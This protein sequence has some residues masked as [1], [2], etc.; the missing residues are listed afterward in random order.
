[1]DPE[2]ISDDMQSPPSQSAGPGIRLPVATILSAFGLTGLVL[3]AASY[4]VGDTFYA[5]FGLAPEDV[6]FTKQAALAHA[7]YFLAAVILVG[8]LVCTVPLVLY[9]VLGD[10]ADYGFISRPLTRLLKR[11]WSHRKWACTIIAVSWLIVVLFFALGITAQLTAEHFIASSGPHDATLLTNTT[12]ITFSMGQAT[13]TEPR[14]SSSVTVR[15]TVA[16]LGESGGMV[17][18]YDY[19]DRRIVRVSTGSVVFSQSLP[20]PG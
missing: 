19:S 1:M 13:W 11:P 5:Q 8:I 2:R 18:M 12:G 3:Y 6:G 20:P 4:L 14:G 10:R 16:L 7:S 9:V 17:V 15:R